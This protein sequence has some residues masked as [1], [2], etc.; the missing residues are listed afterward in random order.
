MLKIWQTKWT[1][2]NVARPVYEVYPSV[3]TNRI[4][5]DFFLNQIITTHGA[6]NAYQNRFFG[7]PILCVCENTAETVH[8]FIFECIKWSEERGKL[9]TNLTD[10]SVKQLLGNNKHRS[11]LRDMMKKRFLLSIDQL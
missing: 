1:A 9:P 7:K 3:N 4:S 6:F 2:S 11:I 5:S 10:F 8:H